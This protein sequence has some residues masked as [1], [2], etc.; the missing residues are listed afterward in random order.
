MLVLK[1][2]RQMGFL[3]SFQPGYNAYGGENISIA[4]VESAGMYI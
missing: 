2:C 3:A 4:I 1:T